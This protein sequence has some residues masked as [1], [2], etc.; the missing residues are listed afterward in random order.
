MNA[1]QGPVNP[2]HNMAHLYATPKAAIEQLAKNAH[3]L[4]SSGVNHY[5]L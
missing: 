3:K 5:R 4:L 1:W 2:A